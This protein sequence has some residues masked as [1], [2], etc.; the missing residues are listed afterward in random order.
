MLDVLFGWYE[1]GVISMFLFGE[2][3]LPTEETEE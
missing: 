3:P 2:Y 1:T